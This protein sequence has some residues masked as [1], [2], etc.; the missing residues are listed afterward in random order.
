MAN[1]AKLGREV[2]VKIEKYQSA[3][4][5]FSHPPWHDESHPTPPR[6][7]EFD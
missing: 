1:C 7:H 5:D 3:D 2:S 4:Q 6:Q